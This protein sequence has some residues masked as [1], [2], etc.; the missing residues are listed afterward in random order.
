MLFF[1]VVKYVYL[2]VFKTLFIWLMFFIIFHV[3]LEIELIIS[4]KFLL[5]IRIIASQSIVK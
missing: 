2:V 3:P 4:L 1:S 5:I